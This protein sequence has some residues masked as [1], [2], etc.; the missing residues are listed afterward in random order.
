MDSLGSAAGDKNGKV[1]IRFSEDDLEAWADFMPPLQGGAEI[2]SDYLLAMLE[3]F[4]IKQGVRWDAIK[5]IALQ[6]NRTRK[7]VKNV[8]VAQ[9]IRPVKEVNEYFE[10]NP[11]LVKQKS[12]VPDKNRND[13]IDYRSHSPFIIVNKD[14]ALATKKP[15]TPGREGKNVHGDLLPFETIAVEGAKPGD[16]TRIDEKYIISEINGQLVEEKRVLNVRKNLVIKGSVGYATGNIIFPGDVIIEGAVSDGF[17]IYSGGSVI[18][19]QTFDVTEVIAKGDLNVAGGIVG[20]GRAF[21]KVGGSIRTKFIQNCKVACRKTIVIEAG[22]VNSNIFVMEKLDLGDRGRILGGEIYAI[23]GIRA[24]SVGKEAG[25]STHIH[26]GVDFTLQ[27][28]QEANNK[29]LQSLSGKLAKLREIMAVPNPDPEKQARLE[30]ALRVLE[31]EQKKA[32]KRS[33]ELMGLVDADENATV[34]VNGEIAAGTLIEICEIALF[35]AEPL[36]HVRIKLDAHTRKLVSEP[37]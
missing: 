16:N 24:G 8:L 25:K 1:V 11:H 34:E 29:T 36:R 6:C 22:I 19:Q 12:P 10:I 17:K 33:V 14:Q 13:Q 18:I 7:P 15:R 37:L 27:K 31:E 5:A 28:E 9:G 4:N 23:K 30:Q 35:V 32:S 26:C 21:L 20:R 3:R 2:T